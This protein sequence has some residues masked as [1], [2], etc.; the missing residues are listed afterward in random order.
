MRVRWTTRKLEIHEG[1][2]TCSTAPDAIRQTSVPAARSGMEF[3]G[4]RRHCLKFNA[5]GTM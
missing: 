3:E 2:P 1:G 5:P 4:P